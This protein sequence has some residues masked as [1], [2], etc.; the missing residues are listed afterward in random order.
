MPKSYTKLI[1][2]NNSVFINYNTIIT[3]ERIAKDTEDALLIY[4]V[5]ELYLVHTEILGSPASTMKTIFK[6]G[7]TTVVAG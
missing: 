5:R 1:F 7:T 4:T 6:L 2:S 3:F